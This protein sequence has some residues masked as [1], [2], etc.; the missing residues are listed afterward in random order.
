MRQKIQV[1]GSFLS[2]MI[3][4]V[5]AAFIAWGLITAFFIPVGWWPNE[6]LASMVDPM[7]KY[8]LPSLIAYQGGNGSRGAIVGVIA[9]MGV[10]T[11]SDI[12]MFLGAMIMAPISAFLMKKIDEKLLNNTRSGFEMLVNN[13]SAGILGFLIAILSFFLV[14][15]F[16][17]SVTNIFGSGVAFLIDNNVLFLNSI[18][19]EPAK[20]LFLNNAINHGVLSPLRIGLALEHGK[21]IFIR[22]KSWSRNWCVISFFF[23]W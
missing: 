6:Q 16:I 17:E 20:I 21:S 19:I 5:M 4:P 12:P 11:G 1:I 3:M 7:I 9:T 18:I 2:S 10:I 22:S 13:Y 14:G 8:M 15:P 23:I